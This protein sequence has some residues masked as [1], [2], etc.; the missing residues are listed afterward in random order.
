MVI[1]VLNNGHFRFAQI[2]NLQS[3]GF[4]NEKEDQKIK[5]PFYWEKTIFVWNINI[6]ERTF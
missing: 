3:N 2:V 1:F 5:T 6:K 4:K